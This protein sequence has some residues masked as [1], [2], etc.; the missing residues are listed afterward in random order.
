MGSCRRDGWPLASLCCLTHQLTKEAPPLHRGV[1]ARV[2]LLLGSPAFICQ[3][4][5]LD[6]RWQAAEALKHFRSESPLSPF[7]LVFSFL[8]SHPFMFVPILLFRPSGPFH[9]QVH[10]DTLYT[11]ALYTQ[12]LTHTLA[13]PLEA[14]L[15]YLFVSNHLPWSHGVDHSSGACE[16]ENSI[17]FFTC[18]S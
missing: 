18:S 8:R 2:F 9:T 4:M 1:Y 17:S 13:L 3:R 16:K 5:L 15:R 6:T 14:V 7:H 10:A 12:S 11:N